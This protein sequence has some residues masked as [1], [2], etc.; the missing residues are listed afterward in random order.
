GRSLLPRQL[1]ARRGEPTVT[2]ETHP[3]A[4]QT[5]H[6]Y[7]HIVFGQPRCSCG[8]IPTGEFDGDLDLEVDYHVLREERD[9]A[10]RERDE[11]IA[12]LRATV[13]IVIWMMNGSSD[14]GPVGRA[15]AHWHVER[16][17][18]NAAFAFLSNFS[19]EDK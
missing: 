13:G 8:F 17:K 1:L 18:L 19:E 9:Q 12:L 11:A 3:T 14:F 10:I 6:E 4:V 7:Q 5:A 2:S 16:E 15:G